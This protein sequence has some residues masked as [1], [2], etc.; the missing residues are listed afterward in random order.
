MKNYDI[1]AKTT[2]YGTKIDVTDGDLTAC[3]RQAGNIGRITV[4]GRGNVRQIKTIAKTFYRAL[5]THNNK[6]NHDY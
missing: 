4:T 2:G 5:H 1:D 3:L 6:V